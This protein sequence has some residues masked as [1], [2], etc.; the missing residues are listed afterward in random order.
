MWEKLKHWWATFSCTICNTRKL[1]KDGYTH[2]LL[3][4][5]ECLEC[6][7]KI[8]VQ[9]RNNQYQDLVHKELRLLKARA[10]AQRIFDAQNEKLF[11]E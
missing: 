1:V 8:L 9:V 2:S 10:E 7:R 5:R 6:E 11:R 4:G 3:G